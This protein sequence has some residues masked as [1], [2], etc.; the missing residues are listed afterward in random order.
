MVAHT[1]SL[2]GVV[3]RTVALRADMR[4]ECRARFVDDDLHAV[5]FLSERVGEALAVLPRSLAV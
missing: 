3:R 5:S 2:A 1:V 4:D